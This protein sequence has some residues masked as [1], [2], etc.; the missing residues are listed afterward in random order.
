MSKSGEVLVAI[1]NN[2]RDFAIIQNQNWYRIPVSSVKKWL[3]KR[4]PP[5]WVAFYLMRHNG[6]DHD[7]TPPIL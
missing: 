2:K 7:D 1:V 5:Q 3:I 4:W 6:L